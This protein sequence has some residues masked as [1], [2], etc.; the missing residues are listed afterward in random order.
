MFRKLLVLSGLVELFAPEGLIGVV[1][2]IAC[3]SPDECELESWVV[4]AARVEGL[5]YLYMGVRGERSYRTFK[6]FLGTVGL[7]A[8]FAPRAS[9]RSVT[10]LAYADPER[11]EWKP[12]VYPLTR[13]FGAVYVLLALDTFSGRERE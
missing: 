2:R 10:K 3:E 4:P 6:R 8:L 1:H 13:L 12:W 5:C 9:I 7:F 11:C